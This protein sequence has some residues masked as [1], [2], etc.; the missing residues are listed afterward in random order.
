[1]PTINSTLSLGKRALLAHQGAMGLGADNVANVNTPGYARKIADLR[2]APGIRNAL[3]A[4]GGGVDLL[5]AHGERDMFIERQVRSAL[6]EAGRG[7]TSHQMLRMIE[8]VFGELSSVGLSNA[9]DRFWNAW[10]DLSNDPSSMTSRNALL[11]TSINLTRKFHDIDRQLNDQAE[12]INEQITVKASRVNAITQELVRINEDLSRLN[13]EAPELVDR[14]SLLL[15]ELTGLTGATYRFEDNGTVSVFL[16]GAAMVM[17]FDRQI[18]GVERDDNGNCSLVLSDAGNRSLNVAT[19][20]IGGLFEV[21]DETLAEL[22]QRLDEL[23]ATLAREVNSVHL[24]GYGLNGSTGIDFF[25][26]ETTGISDIAINY[27]IANDASL[28]AASSDGSPGDNRIALLIAEL[29]NRAVLSDGS[30]TIGEAYGSIA[31]WLGV[32]VANAEIENEGAQLALYQAESWREAV[33]GVSLDEEMA[34]LIASQLAFNA[35]AKLISMADSML[36]QVLALV[37]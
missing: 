28:I 4:F 21:R 32:R 18:I 11:G 8:E 14:C 5:G 7:Q 15:D 29:E 27:R 1:M 12:R 19:G 24:T 33:S 26:P 30:E 17:D 31:T 3:G 22:R 2:S 9:F 16:D 25:D 36:E 34:K 6:G 13:G 10:H 20:E 35:S 37:R 23:A